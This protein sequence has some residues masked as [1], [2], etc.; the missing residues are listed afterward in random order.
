[1][2]N[3]LLLTFIIVFVE[4]QIFRQKENVSCY[5]RVQR[6]NLYIVLHSKKKSVLESFQPQKTFENVHFQLFH[7]KIFPQNPI[8]EFLNFYTPSYDKMRAAIFCL[9]GRN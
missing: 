5:Y 8:T 1:M 2:Q 7:V 6:R 3:I 4:E 9:L